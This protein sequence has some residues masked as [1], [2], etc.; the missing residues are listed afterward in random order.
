MFSHFKRELRARD[1]LGYHRSLGPIDPPKGNSWF[2]RRGWSPNPHYI[3][4]LSEVGPGVYFAG[5][6]VIFPLDAGLG[7]TVESEANRLQ[8]V[9]EETLF[10]FGYDGSTEGVFALPKH[11]PDDAES[12]G[13]L[14]YNYQDRR[15]SSLGRS[16]TDWIEEQPTKLFNKKIYDG[17]RSLSN[18]EGINRVIDD[19]SAFS[20][21]LIDFDRSAVRP[22]GKESDFLPRY[23]KGTVEIVKHRE[24]CLFWL[25]F[26]V[27]RLG[28]K[29]GPDNVEYVSIPVQDIKC[30]IP[31]KKEFYVFDPFNMPFENVKIDY[32]PLIDL[33]SKMRVKY[34]EIQDLL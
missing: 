10:S 26:K 29:V 9:G 20:I 11:E 34:K 5:S 13:V 24:V 8:S 16:F 23:H 25:T 15:V 32:N 4:F 17:F 18:I 7:R 28:S 6:L 12:S 2:L 33:G 30:G 19:R 27:L 22:P 3:K 31:T 14:W 21:Q 1:A